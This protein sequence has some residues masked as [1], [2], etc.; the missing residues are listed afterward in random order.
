MSGGAAFGRNYFNRASAPAM[1]EEDVDAERDEVLEEVAELKRFAANFSHPEAK[2]EVDAA[3]F[4]RNYFNRAS[5]P[6]HDNFEEAEDR[7]AALA[8]TSRLQSLAKDYA[9]PEAGVET[10]DVNACGRN[11]FTRPSAPQS[12]DIECTSALADAASLKK[13]A[14]AYAHPEAP[15]DTSDPA[16]SFRN[17]F[18]RYSSATHNDSLITTSNALKAGAAAAAPQQQAST[19]KSKASA[20]DDGGQE[21]PRNMSSHMLFGMAGAN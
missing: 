4:G 19:K 8:D 16:A 12:E 10:T 7:A 11:Y 21:M 1:E 20:N 3:A 15:V 18:S 9:H 17:Y 6:Q 13:L 14:Q 2:I 5:A